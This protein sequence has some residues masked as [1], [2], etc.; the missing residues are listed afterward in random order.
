MHGN[1]FACQNSMKNGTWPCG[2]CKHRVRFIMFKN[3]CDS[4]NCWC[5]LSKSCG[6]ERLC[7]NE[8]WL[9]RMSH[10]QSNA[11][12]TIYFYLFIYLLWRC[13]PMWTRGQG[14]E[15]PAT[16]HLDAGFSWFSCVREQMLRWYPRCQAATTCF[17]CSPP[18]PKSSSKYCIHV[19]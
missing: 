13:G 7:R 1:T 8:K 3:P 11:V 2:E 4:C 12:S 16:G 10:L 6:F 5:C 14:P 18:R 15:G 9:L 19:N 17:S